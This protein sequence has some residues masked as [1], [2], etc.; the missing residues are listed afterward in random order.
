MAYNPVEALRR[1]GV[2]GGTLTAEVEEFY[3]GLAR[4]ETETLIAVKE[5]LSAV[6][7]EVVAHS[8]DWARPEATR[9]GFD[10]SMMCACG[11]W[12]GSGHA[13]T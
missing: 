12:S 4:A 13:R 2:I 1:A 11:A 7:P 9:E 6:L 3:A 10:A 5:R 8:H